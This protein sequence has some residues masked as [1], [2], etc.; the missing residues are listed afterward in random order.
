M[1]PAPLPV[2]SPVSLPAPPGVADAV[3][4][5]PGRL[6]HATATVLSKL[7]AVTVAGAVASYTITILPPAGM[8]V[9]DT[10]NVVLVN[11]ALA[12][13]T[14]PVGVVETTVAEVY[15]AGNTSLADTSNAV[16]TVPPAAFSMVR[17]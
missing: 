12:P 6:V 7:L 17:V 15:D 3:P 5:T 13:I 10:F 11:A 4:E 14:P 9:A 16:A 8:L 2:R 1:A